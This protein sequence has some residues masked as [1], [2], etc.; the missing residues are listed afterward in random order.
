VLHEPGIVRLGPSTELSVLYPLVPWVGVMAL[1][2]ALGPLFLA[3]ASRRRRLL[4][5]LG[6]ALTAAFLLLRA[7]NRYGDPLPWRPQPSPL[8]TLLAFV[9]TQKYPPSLLFLLM[10]LGPA[11]LASGTISARAPL[12]CA[13]L[14]RPPGPLPRILAVYGR[15]PLF[16]YLL[17][18]PLIHALSRLAGPGRAHSLPIVYAVWLLVVAALYLPCRAFAALKQRRSEWWWSLL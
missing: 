7:L 3:P 12:V 4:F 15:V 5:V 14:H 16:F 11:L 8:L 2:Y 17:H 6:L 18:L 9:N 1:G 10:T 13:W